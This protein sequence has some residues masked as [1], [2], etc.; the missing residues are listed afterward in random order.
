MQFTARE[1]HYR[2]MYP[3]RDD[4]VITC[5]GKP[6]G[7]LIVARRSAEIVLVD[8]ALL[9]DAQGGGKGQ[10]LVRSLQKEAVAAGKPLRLHVLGS[11]GTAIRFYERLGFKTIED[12]GSYLHMEWQP[13]VP[14]E[15]HA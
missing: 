3:E 1:Q 12:D 10:S 15:N 2:T 5:G 9:P 6:A 7:R 8:I 4:Q 13:A 14:G 11:N